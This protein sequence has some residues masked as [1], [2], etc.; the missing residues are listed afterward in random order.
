[1]CVGE[2]GQ[3]DTGGKAMRRSAGAEEE[4]VKDAGL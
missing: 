4:F 1:M 3:A 2:E